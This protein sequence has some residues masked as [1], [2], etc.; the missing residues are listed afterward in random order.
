M[1]RGF[2]KG[3]IDLVFE[4]EAK[5][6]FADWKSDTLRTY[7]PAEMNE[8]LDHDYFWQERLYTLGIVRLLEI[9][10]ASSFEERFGGFFY[11]FLRGV[12]PGGRG[13]LFR[14]PSWEQVAIFEHDVARYYAE[15]AGVTHG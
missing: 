3:V 6:Y 13:V 8:R 7:A 5:I 12:Q 1:E 9:A 14:K 4:H 10:D 11:V 2:I 15:S